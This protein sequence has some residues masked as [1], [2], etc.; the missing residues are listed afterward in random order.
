MTVRHPIDPLDSARASI[1]QALE[2]WDAADLSQ[3][4]RCNV[5]V[6]GAV[7][8]L[9]EFRSSLERGEHSLGRDPQSIL[10]E[11][12]RET[13]RMNRLV[14]A[15]LAFQRGLLLRLGNATPAY[16]ASG[17]PNLTPYRYDSSFGG[18]EA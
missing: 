2:Q 18:L 8:A 6:E 13:V 9:Q 12:Q 15:C 7:A 17:T 11:I 14:D 10:A 5:L 1:Q 3:I 16:G 4:Y